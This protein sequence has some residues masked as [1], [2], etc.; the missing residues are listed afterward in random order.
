[1][2]TWTQKIR[3]NENGENNINLR[4]VRIENRCTTLNDI[5]INNYETVELARAPNMK[6]FFG[7]DISSIIDLYS[8][9]TVLNKRSKKFVDGKK[10]IYNSSGLLGDSCILNDNLLLKL[11]IKE[12]YIGKI[13]TEIIFFGIDYIYDIE[14]NFENVTETYID[15]TEND[16]LVEFNPEVKFK[17][18][19][20][21][22]E[23]KQTE[24]LPFRIINFKFQSPIYKSASVEF[25]S[26][27][28]DL[29]CAIP[30]KYFDKVPM[31]SF[32]TFTND[33]QT[34][35]IQSMKL[36]FSTHFD[37]LKLRIFFVD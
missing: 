37:V 28:Y 34:M 26:T 20:F 10:L 18:L 29:R 12:N 9:K 25:L 32:Y 36:H 1:M 27:A 7:N 2:V 19:F 17:W 23:N 31:N 14:S 4:F 13:E 33:F 22:I 5:V 6:P 16:Q 8:H 30:V 15:I 11:E 24:W 3:V 35:N 21:T